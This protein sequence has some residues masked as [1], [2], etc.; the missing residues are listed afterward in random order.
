M[1]LR[2]WHGRTPE[3][4]AEAYEELVA[5]E[6]YDVIADRTGEGY[7][8]FEMARREDGDEYEYVTVTRFEDWDAVESFAGED[9]RE[10]YVP[11]AAREL[12]T[13]YD[14]EA[15]HYEVVAGESV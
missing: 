2:V 6:N 14:E 11:P 12:L 1:I 4:D 5:E 13:E 7:R 9:Y 8:G 10:A 15:D 3:E